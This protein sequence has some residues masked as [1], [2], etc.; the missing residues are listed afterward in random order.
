MRRIVFLLLLLLLPIA[1]AG[2]CRQQG[3]PPKVEAVPTEV[4]SA[5]PAF[6][7]GCYSGSHC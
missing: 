7:R 2:G 1:I 6:A 5:Y 3:S 4:K